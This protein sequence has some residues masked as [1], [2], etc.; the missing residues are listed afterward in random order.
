MR[1]NTN[2]VVASSNGDEVL[3]SIGGLAPTNS[4]GARSAGNSPRKPSHERPQS[5]SVEP[6]N[7]AVRRKSIRDPSSSPR[8]RPVGGP[9]P[10]L[11]GQESSVSHALTSV[12]EDGP[13]VDEPEAGVERG[14]LFVKVIGLKDLNLPLVK[15]KFLSIRSSASR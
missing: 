13:A 12:V 8:K 1:H 6:W 11:P 5:W 2:L 7:G 14:R 3:P 9:V 15:G 4:R 10:P